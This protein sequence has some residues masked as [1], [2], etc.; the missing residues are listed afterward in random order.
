M[1]VPL[2][3]EI[4]IIGEDRLRR[5]M[6]GTEAELNATASRVE[7]RARRTTGGR[8]GAP[9]RAA[10]RGFDQIGK[11]ARAADDRVIKDRMRGEE[12]ASQQR[13]RNIQRE[14]R[15]Q[16]RAEQQAVAARDRASKASRANFG[17]GV[18]TTVGGSVRG[19]AQMG[20]TVLGIAGGALG[21]LAAT[22]AVESTLN[23]Q[24]EQRAIIRNARGPGQA[25]LISQRE[26]GERVARTSVAT[27]AS[28]EGITGGLSA[29]VAKTGNLSG[30]I[31]NMNTFAQVAMATGASVEDVFSAA[32]DL[33]QKL[34]IDNVKDMQAAFAD[35][36]F[37]GKKGAFE[38]KN[39]AAE[40]PELTST[41]ARMG[42]HGAGGVKTLGGLMQLSMQGTGSGP[43]A[44]TAFQN[45]MNQLVNKAADM[46]SG[47]A[48]GGRKVNV[49]Q[50]GDARNK[51]LEIPDIIA[52]MMQA[53]RGNLT[54]INKVLEIRGNKAFS[55]M[56]AA[57]RTAYQGTQGSEE[58]KA[59][60]GRDAV[61]KLIQDAMS[62]G[63][64]WSDVQQDAQ[65][66]LQDTTAQIEIA[67]TKF[68]NAIGLRLLP[69]LTEL[70]PKF[71]DMVPAVADGAE[72]IANFAQ[73]V[74]ENP[75]PDIGALI[76]GKIA[77]DLAMAG[78][79]AAAK[80]AMTEGLGS[81]S[82][83]G[84][85]GLAIS[86]GVAAISIGA[87]I[88]NSSAADLADPGRDA[89]R[90]RLDL[91]KGNLSEQEMVERRIKLTSSLQGLQQNEPGAVATTLG[92]ISS[93]LGGQS[94]E[95]I[96]QSSISELQKAIAD[97]SKA[98]DDGGSKLV[99]KIDSI[100]NASPDRRNSPVLRR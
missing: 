66:A 82:A 46:Q 65:N 51:M 17:R 68:T 5:V 27:G 90:T 9:D 34:G 98:L 26:L 44:S 97:L 59:K 76:A 25:D 73:Q 70:I 39:M 14:A 84:A 31:E 42:I 75:L 100:S 50:G 95:E 20:G 30:A 94:A 38:I 79:G 96:R 41:A 24:H 72:A 54:E 32:A 4:S 77:A 2:V 58:Q 3:Y 53:S 13:I 28:Q 6:R 86:A 87:L 80:Q 71:T 93:A 36:T 29:F 1:T 12:R 48:F 40:L 57:F 64:Q 92:G 55:P 91:V 15:E 52:N 43:E 21:G 22:S 89:S 37:Q 83:F 67:K 74:I 23:L 33:S 61:V 11:A 35:L 60:A 19:I 10:F 85:G 78:I 47:K 7:S 49:F 88:G 18:A 63:A 56:T 69:A 8:A 16:V 81:L 45:A 62:T 99:A